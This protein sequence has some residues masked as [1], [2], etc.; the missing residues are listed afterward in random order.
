MWLQKKK[1]NAVHGTV[2]SVIRNMM[3]GV[4]VGYKFRMVLAYSHFPIVVNVLEGGKVN[5]SPNLGPLNKELLGIQSKQEDRRP[6]RSDNH[7][8]RGGEEQHNIAGNRFGEGIA[9]LLSNPAGYSDPEQGLESVFGW[10]LCSRCPSRVCR[11]I[12]YLNNYSYG[13]GIGMEE[14]SGR[15]G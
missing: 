10:N 4:T 12:I 11:L 8:E 9:D 7:E 13:V 15:G 6:R 14:E 2:K 3:N 1:R 5:P